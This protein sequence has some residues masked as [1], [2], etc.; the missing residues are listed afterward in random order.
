MRM[1]K[2]GLVLC[3]VPRVDEHPLSRFLVVNDVLTEPYYAKL[4]HTVLRIVK[5]LHRLD[6]VQVSIAL[7][8]VDAKG[9]QSNSDWG[10][11]TRR[12]SAGIITRKSAK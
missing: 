2:P 3:L 9:T 11:T 10:R 5:G 12:D 4:S 1:K 6:E 8:L 7:H